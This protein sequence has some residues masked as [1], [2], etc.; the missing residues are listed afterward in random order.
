MDLKIGAYYSV[1]QRPRATYECLKRFRKY[2]PCAPV[3]LISNNGMDFSKIAQYF[4]CDYVYEKEQTLTKRDPHTSSYKF[5][6]EELAIEHMSR[7]KRTCE[8]FSDVDWILILEDD[9][10]VRGPIK[11]MP[12]A[13]LAG[14]CIVE[15]TPEL[16]QFIYSKYPWLRIYG[17]S[18]CGG[19]IIHKEIFL[20][21]MNNF[22]NI[23]EGRRLDDRIRWYGDA[24]LT[25]LFLY[26]GYETGPAWFDHSE[27]VYNLGS[28]DAAFDHPYKFFYDKPWDDSMLGM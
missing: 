17:Y 20:R 15:F 22:P 10:F 6:S 13:P 2:F 5:I 26:N 21:C 19:T 27:V 11:H 4:Y 16:K 12:P 3:R 23:E 25:Y 24:L 28:P 7:I 9:T 8:R 18:G 1:Y 14:P